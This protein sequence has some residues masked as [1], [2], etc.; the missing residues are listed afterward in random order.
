MNPL[1][2]GLLVVIAIAYFW[3]VGNSLSG[4]KGAS[5]EHWALYRE[6]IAISIESNRL[7]TEELAILRELVA[8][9]RAGRQSPGA[10]PTSSADTN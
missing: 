4:M 7:R 8:E 1:L 3:W 6:G 5:N 2:I 9:L 10:P